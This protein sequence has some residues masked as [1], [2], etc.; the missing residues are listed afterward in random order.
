VFPT[1][2]C[3]G[4]GGGSDAG[5]VLGALQTIAT[6]SGFLR[7]R[8]ENGQLDTEK[9]QFD[10]EKSQFWQALL[11]VHVQGASWEATAEGWAGG[12]PHVVKVGTVSVGSKANLRVPPGPEFPKRFQ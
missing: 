6:R 4:G 3:E 2:A 7:L 1:G 12:G 9:C 8:T 5:R 11:H 10:T